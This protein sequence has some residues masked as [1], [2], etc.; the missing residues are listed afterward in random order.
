MKYAVALLLAKSITAINL[1]ESNLVQEYD[2]DAKALAEI[3][4][5][6]QET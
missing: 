4:Q 5:E 6:T 2:Q 3:T 1:T